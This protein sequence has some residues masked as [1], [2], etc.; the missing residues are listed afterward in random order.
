MH[1]EYTLAEKIAFRT[2]RE[3]QQQAQEQIDAI[4][5]DVMTRIPVPE[6]KTL[7]DSGL[8]WKLEHVE[9]N[10]EEVFGLAE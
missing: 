10:D 4:A 2:L 3:Q 5:R 6:G 9:G 8:V 1:L 7:N